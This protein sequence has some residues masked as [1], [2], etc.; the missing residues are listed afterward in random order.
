MMT[1]LQAIVTV[2]VALIGSLTGT[3]AF[4]QFL[5]KRKDDKEERDIQKM[6]DSS[7]Q[8]S[9]E[10][11]QKE[12]QEGLEMFGEDDRKRSEANSEAIHKN[13]EMIK[14]IIQIQ[15]DTNEKFDKLANS[16]TI[17]SEA[18]AINSKMVKTCAE[19]IRSSNYDKILLVANKALKRHAITISEKANLI[20]LYQSWKDLSGQD[21]RI[22]VYY[23]DCIKLP[24][25]PDEENEE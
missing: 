19:G 16:L 22:Q 18:T 25:I 23:D 24:S 15:K 8:K 4:A 9:K 17:L 6:I 11:V 3:F 14:E 2:I 12:L 5:I 21:P 13:T 1:L 7:V 10:E 20:Q